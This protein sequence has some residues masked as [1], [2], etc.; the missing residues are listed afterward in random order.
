MD[1]AKT[2]RLVEETSVPGQ[3]VISVGRLMDSREAIVERLKH[4]ANRIG[5]ELSW[6]EDRFSD[7]RFKDLK[8]HDL[9]IKRQL[10]GFKKLNKQLDDF[11]EAFI[12]LVREGKISK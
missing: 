9:L 2:R 6:S 7:L 1:I 10:E 5:E 11:Q 8:K 3:E 4:L 12:Q